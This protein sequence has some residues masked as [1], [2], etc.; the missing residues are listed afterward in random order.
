MAVQVAAVLEHLVAQE[1]LVDP[2]MLSSL[3]APRVLPQ[4][5]PRREKMEGEEK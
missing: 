3:P 1:A 4:A 2:L 5:R